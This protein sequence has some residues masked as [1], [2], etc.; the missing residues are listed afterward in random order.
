MPKHTPIP[1][2]FHTPDTQ[3]EAKALEQLVAEVHA[4]FVVSFCHRL[5]CPAAQKR[6]LLQ[7]IICISNKTHT[8]KHMK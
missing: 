1:I 5:T 2:S 7:A 4:D 8:S 3:K 6:Q